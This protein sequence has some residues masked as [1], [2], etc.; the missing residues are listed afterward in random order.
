MRKTDPSFDLM[1]GTTQEAKDG[2]A[3]FRA[4]VVKDGDTVLGE[5]VTVTPQP[6]ASCVIIDSATGLVKALVGGRGWS[7]GEEQR[8]PA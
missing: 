3:A 2:A 6:Q 4:S 8:K 1:Y 5:R 7:A